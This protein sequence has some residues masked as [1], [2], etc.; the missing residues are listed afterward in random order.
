LGVDTYTREQFGTS[1]ELLVT[2]YALNKFRGYVFQH[3]CFHPKTNIAT[4][5]YPQVKQQPPA[6][7]GIYMVLE[8]ITA[9]IL[10]VEGTHYTEILGPHISYKLRHK[11][12]V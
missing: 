5:V 12:I 3:D 11:Q 7:K 4:Y 1:T 10:H 6:E 9:S 2:V 8:S